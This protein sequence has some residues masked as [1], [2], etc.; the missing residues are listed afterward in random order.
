MDRPAK[1]ARLS[2]LRA[3][4]PYI[5]QAALSAVLEEVNRE[6]APKAS[7]KDIRAAR[8]DAVKTQTAYGTLHQSLQV[9]AKEGPPETLEYQHPG[10]MLC[11]LVKHSPSLSALVS[12]TLLS[13]PCSPQQPWNVLVYTDEVLPGNQLAYKHARKLWAV[14]WSVAEWGPAALADEEPNNS[15]PTHELPTPHI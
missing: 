1:V 14:Y 8:D 6:A 7:R 3:R 5:S 9:A 2:S 11:Y 4:L 15:R 13:K 10:A 12:R